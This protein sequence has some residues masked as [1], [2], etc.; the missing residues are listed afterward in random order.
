M[1]P[2]FGR[3]LGGRLSYGLGYTGHGLG[4]TRLAGRILAHMAL[5]R[6]SELLDLSLVRRKPF[7]YPA[8][9]APLVVG[10]R[11]DARASA[12]RPGRAAE[13]DAAGAGA[14][15]DRVLELRAGERSSGRAGERASGRARPRWSLARVPPEARSPAR[16]PLH[17]PSAA[18]STSSVKS[19]SAAV[20]HIGG[21]MRS[22]LPNS[23]PLPIS[24]PISR[25]ASHTASVS[26]VAGSLVS[27]SRTSSTP[28]IRPMP[29]TSPMS[30]G[31]LELLEPGL[32]VAADDP[33]SS[34]GCCP[35]R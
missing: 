1:T 4:T 24:T 7:P 2:Y 31:G 17:P 8:G 21:L 35:R 33:A 18:S 32:E 14:A 13:P 10:G 22:V 9:A 29:R 28:S 23:P 19:T 5:D 6:P 15:G 12:G 3:A 26:C 27:R 11:G 25:I 16:L 34:P 20:M 30:R